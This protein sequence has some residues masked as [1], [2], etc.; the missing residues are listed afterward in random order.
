MI[1]E[2]KRVDQT[3]THPDESGQP[4]NSIFCNY[5]PSRSQKHQ[6]HCLKTH[7]TNRPGAPSDNLTNKMSEPGR[8][9]R[10]SETPMWGNT[11]P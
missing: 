1:S 9:S 3:I 8:Y 7:I 5:I 10:Q 2:Q 11:G 4:Q 6:G